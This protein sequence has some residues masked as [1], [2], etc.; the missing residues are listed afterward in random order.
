VNVLVFNSNDPGINTLSTNYDGPKSPIN[1]KP[2]LNRLNSS[3][4]NNNRAT[5]TMTSNHF[6]PKYSNGEPRSSSIN[7]NSSKNSSTS[8]ANYESASTLRKK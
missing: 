4:N 6:A 7:T 1:S 5:V 3:N 8:L 2:T